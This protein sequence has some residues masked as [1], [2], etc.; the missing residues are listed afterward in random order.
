MIL[1]QIA[2]TR[3]LVV[4]D[5]RIQRNRGPSISDNLAHPDGTDPHLLSDLS[6]ARLAT[7]LLEQ[8]VRDALHPVDDFHRVQGNPY[9]VGLVCERTS[10]CLSNRPS[11]VGREPTALVVVE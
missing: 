10:N 1:N 4:A 2:Q 11:R 7:Q 6:V 3:L 5:L 9:G 8:A